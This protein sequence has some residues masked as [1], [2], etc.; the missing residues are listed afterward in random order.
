[1]PR[2]EPRYATLYGGACR[3]GEPPAALVPTVEPG[4]YRMP[5]WEDDRR[6]F[7]TGECGAIRGTPQ[8]L[9]DSPEGLQLVWLAECELKPMSSSK[10]SSKR[11]MT[12]RPRAA[13]AFSIDSHIVFCRFIFCSCASPPWQFFFASSHWVGVTI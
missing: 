3:V 11:F 12:S 10:S 6:A 9:Y 2:R 13:L 5:P 7:T 1:M 8:H 4:G